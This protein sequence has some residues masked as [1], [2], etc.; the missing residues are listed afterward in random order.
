MLREALSMYKLLIAAAATALAVPALAQGQR[1][2]DPIEEEIVPIGRA[3]RGQ[4]P[5]LA[6]L[7]A[8]LGGRV[9]NGDGAPTAAALEIADGF[10]RRLADLGTRARREAADIAGLTSTGRRAKRGARSTA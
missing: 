4:P 6:A 10:D 3:V 5:R 7:I 1:P 8:G 2:V 9:G